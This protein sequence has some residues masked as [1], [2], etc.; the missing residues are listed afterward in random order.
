M[1]KIFVENLVVL[2]KH[3]VF[4]DEQ[5]N[6]Q[7]FLVDIVA[8]M[9]THKSA[10]SDNVKDTVD[11]VSFVDS[12]R[13]VIEG[14]SVYLVEK[15]AALIAKRILKDERIKEVSVSIRKP[16]VLSSGVPGVTI[17]RTQKG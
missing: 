7:E 13:E 1:D 15:L 4:E 9:D 5:R 10:D 2:G 17:I 3:G 8:T 6:E 11:Y 12:A 14:T 16:S